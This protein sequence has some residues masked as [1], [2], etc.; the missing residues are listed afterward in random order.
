MY[1]GTIQYAA[2]RRTRLCCRRKQP[3]AR[4]DSAAIAVYC[5]MLP[6]TAFGLVLLID[7][8]VRRLAMLMNAFRQRDADALLVFIDWVPTPANVADR[9][10]RN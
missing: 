7:K 8:F 3:T 10:T 6:L 5:T 2:P 1:H 4:I 9:P